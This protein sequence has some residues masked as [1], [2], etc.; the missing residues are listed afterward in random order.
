MNATAQTLFDRIAC[1]PIMDTHEH[2]PL[3]PQLRTT[4]CDVLTEYLSHY[5]C[6]DLISAGMPQSSLDTARDTTLDIEQRFALLQPWWDI[7]RTTGYGQ[8]LDETV[9]GLY[10]EKRIDASTIGRINEAFQKNVGNPLY[11]RHVLKD[12]C[13]IRLSINDGFAHMKGDGW[14][15]DTLFAQVLRLD[16]YLYQNFLWD[17]LAEYGTDMSCLGGFLEAV[18]AD[19]L[20]SPSYGYKGYKLGVAYSRPLLFN[21]VDQST[22]TLQYADLFSRAQKDKQAEAPRELQDYILHFCL[23]ILDEMGAFLQIHTG[24][25]EGNG[26]YLQHTDPLQLTN[27][28]F[29]YP[30]VTFDLFHIGYPYVG[31]TGILG[32]QFPN[33]TVDFA[34]VNIV[35][36]AA[37]QRALDEYLDVMPRNKIFAFGGDYLFVDGIYGHQMMARRMVARTL[38][39]KVDCGT[40]DLEEAVRTAG[41]LLHDNVLDKLGIKM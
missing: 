19:L 29:K 3:R 12:R 28:F 18:R 36:P 7:C 26:N 37:A 40:M 21:E 23:S 5:F 15:D 32:K 1:M 13:N 11:F 38:A 4:P 25:Q 27:L 41:M 35:S 39:G 20:A 6:M 33:V 8:A 2:L 22:A 34:W 14:S 9:Q 31:Q 17:L 24:F 30:N 16:G 10:G